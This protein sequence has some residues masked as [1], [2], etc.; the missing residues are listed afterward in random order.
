[1]HEGFHA[2]CQLHIHPLIVLT[3]EMTY[4]VDIGIN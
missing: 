2:L 4:T 3:I 1:M